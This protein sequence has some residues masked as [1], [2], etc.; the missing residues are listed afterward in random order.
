MNYKILATVVVLISFSLLS[1]TIDL[2]NL[3][4]YENQTIPAY[5]IKDNTTDNP[6]TDEGATLGR[7][8]FYDK[9]LSTDNTVSCA[10]CHHQEFAFGDTSFV[11]QGVN[12]VT[13]RHSMRLINSRFSIE[14]K[15]FWDER[16]E[17]LE[18]Q[19]TM[20][21]RDHG[22][23]GF[24]GENGDPAFTDLLNKLDAISYY[25]DLFELAY[26]DQEINED[27]IQRALA[28]F[29]RSIQ[30][31]DSK[32]DLGRA[33]VNND[34]RPFPNFT[35]EENAGKNLFIAR[36][37][38]DANSSRVGGGLGC[39]ACHQPPEFDIDPNSRSNSMIFAAG[40]VPGP[41]GILDT[42]VTRAPTLRDIFNPEGI[43]GHLM[44]NSSAESFDEVLS[45]YDSIANFANPRYRAF[46]DPRLRPGGMPQRLNMTQQERDQMLAFITTLTGSDVYT[47]EKWSYPFD[48]DGHLEL[49][50]IITSN[51][52][53][54]VDLEIRVYPNP[55][56]ND[57]TIEGDV[58]NM[59]LELLNGSGSG[60]LKIAAV[61]NQTTIDLSDYPSGVYLIKLTNTINNRIIIKRIIKIQ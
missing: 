15:F 28:Q 37:I 5:I 51:N 33:Q 46:I 6:I 48:E 59:E 21:I 31:F 57:I 23:M 58:S 34:G 25:D 61:E 50:G 22:E 12:G 55:F 40:S 39:A 43:M 52:E 24:S 60:L 53:H 1:G 35:P 36:P 30:S 41:D 14:D 42:I 32:Y 8:L 38:F 10:S 17:T 49:T 4:D 27:R 20:P 47:N 19:S 11:S 3:F 45:I 56:I 18:A 2:N 16:A 44:H 54:D 26:G 29:V 9:N 13:G 7:V